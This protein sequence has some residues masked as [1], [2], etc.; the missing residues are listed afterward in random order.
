MEK[1]RASVDHADFKGIVLQ[2]DAHDL[3]P[4]TAQDQVNI[5]S[6]EPGRATTRWG[7]KEVSFDSTA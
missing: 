7:L 1:P 4:G 5:K 6:D 2:A 3:A